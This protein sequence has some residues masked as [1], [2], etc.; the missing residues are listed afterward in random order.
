MRCFACNELTEFVDD[1]KT[2]RFYCERCW[3]PTNLV[4]SQN[5]DIELKEFWKDHNNSLVTLSDLELDTLEEE[6]LQYEEE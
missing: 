3:E 5:L 1:V 6:P 2:D 4:I